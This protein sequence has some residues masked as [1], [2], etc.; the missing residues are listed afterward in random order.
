MGA[1]GF[2][3]HVRKKPE[4]LD[5][6]NPRLEF[7]EHSDYIPCEHLPTF[8]SNAIELNLHRIE[9]LA[10]H[11][12]LFCDDM[13]L[14]RPIPPEYF[15]RTANCLPVLPCDLGIPA[16]IGD[17]NISR[18]ILNNAGLLKRKLDVPGGIRRNKSKF[19]SVRNLGFSR[20]A[21]N[22]ASFAVNRTMIQGCFGHLA[23]PHLKSTF[24]EI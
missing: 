24:E 4:W 11:F 20:A 12:V 23:V 21:K 9:G 17:S 7:V 5:L 22:F 3:R 8:H 19:F 14:L 6:S 13:F 10:E 2:L 16:W 15:F 18:I 1:Q